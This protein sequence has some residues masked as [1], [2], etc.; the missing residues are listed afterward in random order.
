MSSCD[1][2]N[3]TMVLNHMASTDSMPGAKRPE[4][5]WDVASATCPHPSLQFI[6]WTLF[7]VCLF[8]LHCE[9]LGILVP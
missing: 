7:F 5:T 9:A 8:E 4:V 1:S 6:M 2:T 3:Q